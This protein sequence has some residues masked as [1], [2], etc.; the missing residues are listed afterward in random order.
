MEK[1]T[2]HSGHFVTE[3]RFVFQ[4]ENTGKVTE[5]GRDGGK[6]ISSPA[7]NRTWRHVF[8]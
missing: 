6:E 2:C 7:Q 3:K 1:S 8:Q 5:L 4:Q